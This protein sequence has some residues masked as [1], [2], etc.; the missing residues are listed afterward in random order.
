MQFTQLK[1]T[2]MKISRISL[3]TNAVGGHNLYD[4]VNEEQGKNFVR[5]AM[6]EGMNF[7]DTANIYGK[8]RSEELVGEV[9]R[10]VPRD[11]MI[12]ATKGANEWFPDGSVVLNNQP[13]F[14]RKSLEDSLKRLQTDYVDLHYIHNPDGK[15]PIG[16]AVAELAKMKE[17]GKIRAIGVSNMTLEQVKEAN[18]HGDIHA[19]QLEYSMLNR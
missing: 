16:D 6:D 2:D 15:T 17:E 5:A 12:L 9:L 11:S 13:A 4:N 3:G 19:L 10:E 18:A 8:G 7:I 1:K 14:L